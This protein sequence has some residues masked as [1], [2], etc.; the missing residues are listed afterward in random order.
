MTE[1]PNNVFTL[2]NAVIVPRDELELLW[3]V[4]RAA[5]KHFNIVRG[6]AVGNAPEARRKLFD[7]VEGGGDPAKLVVAAL[8][9]GGS[10]SSSMKPEVVSAG[11][12]VNAAPSRPQTPGIALNAP[13]PRR[14]VLHRGV[15]R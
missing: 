6:A 11:M 10:S 8:I 15:G 1:K 7:V 2:P 4:Y 13:Y 12:N 14:S 3:G 5:R 9:D